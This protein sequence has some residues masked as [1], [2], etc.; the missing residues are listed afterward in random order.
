MTRGE[1]KALQSCETRKPRF[2]PPGV[3]SGAVEFRPK[4][5]IWQKN[6]KRSLDENLQV[7]RTAS[8]QVRVAPSNILGGKFRGNCTRSIAAVPAF[9]GA[10]EI[11][12]SPHRQGI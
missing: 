6:E 12:P 1:G 9:S 10:P 5:V 8:A 7:T 11:D 2:P 3:F 4:V